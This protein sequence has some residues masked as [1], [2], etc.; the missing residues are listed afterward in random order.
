LTKLELLV[1]RVK[2]RDSKV[3]NCP[4]TSGVC[5]NRTAYRNYIGPGQL[6]AYPQVSGDREVSDFLDTGIQGRQYGRRGQM[7]DPQVRPPNCLS[8]M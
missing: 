2:R 8:F 7:G 3:R 4:V 1:P 5:S 6:T